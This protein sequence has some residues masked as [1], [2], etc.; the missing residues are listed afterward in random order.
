MFSENDD[1]ISYE[2][3]INILSEMFQELDE[4]TI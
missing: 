2:E 4:H 3:A 1:A